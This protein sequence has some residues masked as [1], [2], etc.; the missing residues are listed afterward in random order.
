[1]LAQDMEE[2]KVEAQTSSAGMGSGTAA[3]AEHFSLL[4]KL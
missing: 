1:M 3:G 2:M 4:V